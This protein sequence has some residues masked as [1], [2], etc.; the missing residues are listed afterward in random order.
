[1]RLQC[2]G[3]TGVVKPQSRRGGVKVVA[4]VPIG[5]RGRKV[6]DAVLHASMALLA[7]RAT[8]TSE[9]AAFRRKGLPTPAAATIPADFP[10]HPA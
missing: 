9:L 3:M 4:D 8:P 10:D 6:G 5:D 7:S 2:I 1:M